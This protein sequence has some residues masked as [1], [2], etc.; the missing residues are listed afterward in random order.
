MGKRGNPDNGWIYVPENNPFIDDLAYFDDDEEIPEIIAAQVGRRTN[1][2]SRV[3][4]VEVD[5]K[6]QA[7]RVESLTDIGAAKKSAA[8]LLAEKAK[9]EA[10]R[11]VFRKEFARRQTHLDDQH[12]KREF[13]RACRSYLSFDSTPDEIHTFYRSKGKKFG[14]F[15]TFTDDDTFL[16]TKACLIKHIQQLG[17]LHVIGVKSMG[18]F[19]SR[20][21]EFDE[22]ANFQVHEIP[23]VFSKFHH[24]ESFYKSEEAANKLC[25]MLVIR[26][27]L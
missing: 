5:T 8:E 22:A 16:P 6:A 13:D 25:N 17:S 15:C 9:I 19:V 7:R 21:R 27:A 3:G 14:V 1:W 11:D 12:Q 23:K 26:Q 20:I 2:S 4:D 18:I 10:G 24:V